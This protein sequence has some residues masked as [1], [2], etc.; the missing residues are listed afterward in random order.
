MRERVSIENL[1]IFVNER[2]FAYTNWEIFFTIFSVF[3]ERVLSLS[4]FVFCLERKIFFRKLKKQISKRISL[5]ILYI[6]VK[7]WNLV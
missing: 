4:K 5:E 3:Y 1:S 2:E 7:K 6:F